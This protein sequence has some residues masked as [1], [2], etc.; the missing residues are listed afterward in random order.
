MLK[1]K[2]TFNENQKVLEMTIDPPVGTDFNMDNIKELAMQ[3]HAISY[4]ERQPTDGSDSGLLVNPDD[5]EMQFGVATYKLPNGF[6]MTHSIASYY[7]A[8][9]RQAHEGAL[10]KGQT[11]EAKPMVAYSDVID[12][13]LPYFVPHA[14]VVPRLNS[15]IQ[16]LM[17][18]DKPVYPNDVATR[19][20]LEG[21]FSEFI[22]AYVAAGDDINAFIYLAPDI[23][24]IVL[25]K[26]TS[27]TIEFVDNHVYL[28]YRQQ[29]AVL[30]GSAINTY[31]NMEIHKL[32]LQVGLSIGNKLANITKPLE[33]NRREAFKFGKP[34]ASFY[35]WTFSFIIAPVLMIFTFYTVRVGTISSSGEIVPII[36]LPISLSLVTLTPVFIL[37]SR[38]ISQKQRLNRYRMRYGSNL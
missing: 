36:P 10:Q 15:G 3:N 14:L 9:L 38:Y 18:T 37:L 26:L 19:V 2:H 33:Q 1:S 8:A 4:V 24:E 20:K 21:D 30:A 7:P 31:I 29:N 17:A 13:S 5:S 27:F 35:I 12:I 16:A 28:Y 11:D 23:M 34:V 22:D 6:T 25:E 32:V